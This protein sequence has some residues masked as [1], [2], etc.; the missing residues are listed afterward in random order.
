MSKL[1]I[2][3]YDYTSGEGGDGKHNILDSIE[4]RELMKT[5]PGESGSA[6]EWVD[7]GEV[8]SRDGWC[9]SSLWWNLSSPDSPLCQKI[10]IALPKSNQIPAIFCIDDSGIVGKFNVDYTGAVDFMKSHL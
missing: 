4:T 7:G 3:V 10:G 1:F 2:L 5:L 9:F 6:Q 8:R